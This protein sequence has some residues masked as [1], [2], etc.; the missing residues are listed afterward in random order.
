MLPVDRIGVNARM[1][2]Q[3]AQ[4][5]PASA[6][7]GSAVPQASSE[8]SEALQARQNEHYAPSAP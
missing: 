3:K 7:P 8:A 4:K 1:A 2:A 6:P 5:R